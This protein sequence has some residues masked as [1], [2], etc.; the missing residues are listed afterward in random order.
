M[1][2]IG[3]RFASNTS[4]TDLSCLK[5]FGLTTITGGNTRGG[6]A[7]WMMTNL[8]SIELPKTLTTIGGNVFGNIAAEEISLPYITAFNCTANDFQN[9]LFGAAFAL[10]SESATYTKVD[11]LKTIHLGV[12]VTKICQLFAYGRTKLTTITLPSNS[13]LTLENTN[14]FPSA[15]TIYVK[16]E[17]L[18]QY[19]TATNWSTLYNEG[20]IKTISEY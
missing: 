12:K 19:A 16:D 10:V 6:G 17:L 11:N 13:V 8:T 20:R 9:K 4:I 15:T 3:T 14:A 18:S 5:Y 7:F 2:N 1:T